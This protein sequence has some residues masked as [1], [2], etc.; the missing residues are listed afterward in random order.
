MFKQRQQ[1]TV[2]STLRHRP[3]APAAPDADA[4]DDIALLGFVAQAASLVGARRPRGA[5]DHI[6]LAKLY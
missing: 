6:E 1:H 5:V 2:R 4:V 3:L